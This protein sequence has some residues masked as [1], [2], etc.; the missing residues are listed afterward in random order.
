MTWRSIIT[1]GRLTETNNTQWGVTV[2]WRAD[3]FVV[4]E[5]HVVIP[6]RVVCVT[7]EIIGDIK[8]EPITIYGCY[9]PQR[10]ATREVI[11]AAWDVVTPLV[12]ADPRAWVVGDLNAEPTRVVIS[13]GRDPTYA[14]QRLDTLIEAAHLRYE[15][16]G[17]KTHAKG[18]ER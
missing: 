7:L 5:A 8:Q 18:G 14:D 13:H 16:D 15:S 3:K 4:K 2:V 1:P 9:M 17:R 12:V 6:A 10:Q 11:D